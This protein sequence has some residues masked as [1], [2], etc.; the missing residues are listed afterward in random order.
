MAEPDVPAPV[1]IAGMLLTAVCII[2]Y[3][4]LSTIDKAIASYFLDAKPEDFD[5]FFRN[6]LNFSDTE[7]KNLTFRYLTSANAFSFAPGLGGTRAGTKFV[8]ISSS[9][10]EDQFRKASIG[11]LG[12]SAGGASVDL[13][14][15]EYLK[16]YKNPGAAKSALTPAKRDALRMESNK[17]LGIP[18]ACWVRLYRN[19][20][21][22]TT[23]GV[24]G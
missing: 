22:M 6:A 23:F 3:A 20:S 9:E 12:T 13:R 5:T 11:K 24:R 18:A 8:G 15:T 7:A 16:Q 19:E 1:Y 17:M 4:I 21:R 14:L 10:L 2:P